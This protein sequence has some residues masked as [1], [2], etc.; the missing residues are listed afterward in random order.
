MSKERWKEIYMEYKKVI[1][2]DLKL[3]YDLI[4]EERL[5]QLDQE[6]FNLPEDKYLFND[7]SSDDSEVERR[8]RKEKKL[9]I[10]RPRSPDS[11]ECCESNC[12]VDCVLVLY[13]D[14]LMI[15]EEKLALVSSDEESEED[16]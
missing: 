16:T 15:Y 5:L 12:G 10:K 8:R 1:L 14:R 9:G 6:E 2:N 3:P 11:D 13:N 4:K 7:G